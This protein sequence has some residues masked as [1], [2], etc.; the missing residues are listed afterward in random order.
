MP[1]S[2]RIL[3]R[4]VFPLDLRIGYTSA[5]SFGVVEI[6][7]LLGYHY[8]ILYFSHS[9][10]GVFGRMAYYLR[11]KTP[12]LAARRFI[13]HWFSEVPTDDSAK[14]VLLDK[15]GKTSLARLYLR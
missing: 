10:E 8:I 7:L 13:T 6:L 2:R 14:S 12:L 11:P 15:Y 5:T 9:T 3:R 1:E 4:T